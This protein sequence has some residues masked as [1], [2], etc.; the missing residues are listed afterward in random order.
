M[1]IGGDDSKED[2]IARETE[3]VVLWEIAS[4]CVT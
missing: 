3:N 4:L 2:E 1:E